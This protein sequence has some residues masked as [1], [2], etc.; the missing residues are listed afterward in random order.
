[1][2]CPC[3]TLVCLGGNC[4]QLDTIGEGVLTGNLIKN[5]TN[6]VYLS[7]T[8]NSV[9]STGNNFKGCVASV[10]ATQSFYTEANNVL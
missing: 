4:I 7:N 6:A 5:F 10:N 9:L 1:M 2:A 3:K 8:S